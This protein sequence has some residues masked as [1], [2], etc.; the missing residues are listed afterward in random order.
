[1]PLYYPSSLRAKNWY[2]HSYWKF[3]VSREGSGINRIQ[4]LKLLIDLGCPIPDK[5]HTG[6]VY[7]K[8]PKYH[9]C[10][11]LRQMGTKKCLKFTSSCYTQGSSTLLTGD[12]D[13]LILSKLLVLATKLYRRAVTQPTC[14]RKQRNWKTV[15]KQF[16]VELPSVQAQEYS[17]GSIVT[18]SDEIRCNHHPNKTLAS[19][20]KLDTALMYFNTGWRSLTWSYKV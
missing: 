20:I 5:K 16:L 13:E 9:S 1:M 2:Y 12:Y 11:V 8:L 19:P 6:A 15:K 10:Q 7:Y 14:K 17:C 3:T 4:C 18:S